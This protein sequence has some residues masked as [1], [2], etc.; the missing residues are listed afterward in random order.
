MIA[1]MRMI[2]SVFS[3]HDLFGSFTAGSYVFTKDFLRTNPKTA[4]HFV[5]ATARAIEWARGTPRDQVIERMSAIIGRRGRNEDTAATKYWKSTGV[6]GRG[7]LIRDREFQ[8]WI[9][10]LVK[11]GQLEPGQLAPGQLYT[12]ELNPFVKEPA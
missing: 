6:A 8:I 1:M 11:D 5:E 3:D 2:R 12:N 9:D 10:W 4:R 7:G